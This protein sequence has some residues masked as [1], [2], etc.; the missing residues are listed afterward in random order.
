MSQDLDISHLTPAERIMLAEQ[1]WD[2]LALGAE[3]AP[4]PPQHFEELNRRVKLEASGEATM[5]SWEEIK[6][7]LSPKE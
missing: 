6:Q 5:V 4:I 1:L 2:S 7:E 3:K